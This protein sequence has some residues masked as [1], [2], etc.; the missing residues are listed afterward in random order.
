MLPLLVLALFAFVP[1]FVKANDFAGANSYFLYAVSVS[2]VPSAS[3]AQSCLLVIQDSDR[4]AVLDAM[5]S[6][7]MKR[8]SNIIDSPRRIRL[9]NA[10]DAMI[11]SCVFS[12][13]KLSKARRGLALLLSTTSR[14]SQVRWTRTICYSVLTSLAQSAATMTVFST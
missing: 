7:N 13:P 14:L 5:Q 1:A 3:S 10:V 6:A 8:R 2:N 4:I 12:S 11:Q 9:V